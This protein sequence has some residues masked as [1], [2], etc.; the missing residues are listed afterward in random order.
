MSAFYLL[1]ALQFA[2]VFALGLPLATALMMRDRGP[3][4]SGWL[5]LAPALGATF[6]F[7][8]GTIMHGFGFRAVGVFSTLVGVSALASIVM[9]GTCKRQPLRAWLVG[10]VAC[11]LAAALA[12]A[13][14]SGDLVFAGLDYFPLTNDDTFA[15]LGHIDQL[16]MTGWIEPRIA[17]P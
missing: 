8:A 7:S 4:S 6:Y 17:Y 1:G 9:L 12:L 3:Q 16:R 10:A 14:N 15:Y 2:S 5:L 11:F 13:L